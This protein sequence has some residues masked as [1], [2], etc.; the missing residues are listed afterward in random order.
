MRPCLAASMIALLLSP[1]VRAQE[2]APPS[3]TPAEVKAKLAAAT[4]Q[5]PPDL[6]GA[7]LIGLELDGVDF[8]RAKLTKARLV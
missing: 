4:E 1:P 2:A 7:D 6:S 3:L 5:S 8:R